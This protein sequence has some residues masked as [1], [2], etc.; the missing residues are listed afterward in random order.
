MSSS[1]EQRYLDFINI[2]KEA[3][4]DLTTENIFKKGQEL[5][6]VVK[7]DK[8]ALA[9]TIRQLKTKAAKRKGTLE[10]FWTKAVSQPAKK[11]T[12]TDEE[13][14]STQS[15]TAT[16]TTSKPINNESTPILIAEGN[17]ISQ[18]L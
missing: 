9:K 11:K 2:F 13:E 7:G 10:S 8:E 18:T 1:G 3:N 14:K 17:N 5:W 6:N 16:S 4:Q 15:S 12:R